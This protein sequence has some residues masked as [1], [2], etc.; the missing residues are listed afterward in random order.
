MGGGPLLRHLRRP[1]IPTIRTRSGGVIGTALVRRCIACSVPC[2]PDQTRL[3]RD[4]RRRRT[5]RHTATAL[6]SAQRTL[7]ACL[8]AVDQSGCTGPAGP[9]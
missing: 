3:A 9:R 1:L 7:S 4:V 2:D 8:H 5:A 6:R